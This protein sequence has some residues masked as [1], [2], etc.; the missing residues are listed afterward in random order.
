MT[1]LTLESLAG[2]AQTV[3]VDFETDEIDALVIGTGNYNP[4]ATPESV[5]RENCARAEMQLNQFSPLTHRHRFAPGNLY[6]VPSVLA[7]IAP[8]GAGLSLYVLVGKL[9]CSNHSTEPL[10]NFRD[11]PLQQGYVISAGQRYAVNAEA[12]EPETIA[13]K[14]AFA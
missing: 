7:T 4:G 3:C 8:N 13:W 1:V 6:N 11:V 10:P 12:Q 14:V 9:F 5:G 2:S